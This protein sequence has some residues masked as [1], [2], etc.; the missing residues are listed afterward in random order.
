MKSRAKQFAAFLQDAA[1]KTEAEQR[2]ESEKD[3]PGFEP[4]PTWKT[5]GF[6]Q[7]D[8]HPA[9]C[10]TWNDAVRFCQWL[11]EKEGVTYRLPTEA[12]W[13]YACLRGGDHALSKWR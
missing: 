10:I 9:V 4:L 2:N 13:E 3:K 6:P 7:Q 8:N 5:P 1:Y 12:E 11:S